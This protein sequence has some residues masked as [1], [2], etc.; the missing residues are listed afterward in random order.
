MS[1]AESGRAASRGT[2]GA[3]TVAGRAARAG[4]EPDAPASPETAARLAAGLRAYVVSPYGDMES[5]PVRDRRH[6]DALDMCGR[7]IAGGVRAY[8]PIVHTHHLAGAGHA[9]PD[10][11][12]AYDLDMIETYGVL[13]VALFPGWERS[14]GVETGRMRS[15]GRPVLRVVP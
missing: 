12:Y 9:P 3:D 11:W 4:V 1:H 2:G 10:G 15:L 14:R 7:L 8:S 6:A 5:K 13:A